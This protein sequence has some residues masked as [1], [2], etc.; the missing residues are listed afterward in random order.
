MLRLADRAIEL[1]DQIEAEADALVKMGIN[2]LDAL[3]LASACSAKAGYF[4]TCDDKLLKKS[5]SL[6]VATVMV[7]PLEFVAE[8]AP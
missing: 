1:T 2:P 8:V 5:K 4:C 6:S 7:S 3:H